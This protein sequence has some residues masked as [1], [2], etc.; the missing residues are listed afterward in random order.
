MNKIVIALA[1]LLSSCLPMPMS[2]QALS[3][4][5]WQPMGNTGLILPGAKLCT[6]AAGTTT[7]QATF[8]DAAGTPNTNPVTLDS[9]GRANVWVNSNAYKFILYNAGTGN[10]CNGSAVGS[11]IWSL[12]NYRDW[13]LVAIESGIITGTG[14]NNRC[15]QWTGTTSLAA[16][17]TPCGT[18]TGSGTA[19]ALPVFTG[20]GAI[21]D[22]RVTE[23]TVLK[24]NERMLVNGTSSDV[25]TGA[26]VSLGQ[27]TEANASV[28]AQTI[29]IYATGGGGGRGIIESSATGSATAK[30]VAIWIEGMEW[31]FIDTDGSITFPAL[32]C[33]SGMTAPITVNDTGKLVQGSCS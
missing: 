15:V 4:A 13:G 32:A 31:L 20:T 2:G 1:F 11:L 9:N 21:G 6:Y 30:G 3:G 23:D 27:I 14:T 7:P 29:R 28:N 12:D 5:I 16:T 19:G 22:S 26:L 25:S 33:P 18:I 17:A 8:Q 24:V 10:N